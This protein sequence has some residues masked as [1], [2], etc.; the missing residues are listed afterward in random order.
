MS[1]YEWVNRDSARN[2]TNKYNNLVKTVE[3]LSSTNTSTLTPLVSQVNTLE[4]TVSENITNIQKTLETI[5]S[6][7]NKIIGQDT[8]EDEPT[9]SLSCFTADSDNLVL[10]GDSDT[11]GE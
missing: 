1:S 2:M 4:K 11:G 10:L 6:Q 8:W 3:D 9:I 5:K 7:L